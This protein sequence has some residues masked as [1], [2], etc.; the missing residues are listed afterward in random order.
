[1]INEGKGN[2]GRDNEMEERG[3]RKRLI[4]ERKGK[5]KRLINERHGEGGGNE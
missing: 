4:K 1:M 5:R 3:K 2:R